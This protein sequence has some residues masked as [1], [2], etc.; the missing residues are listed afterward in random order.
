MESK[1]SF[2]KEYGSYKLGTF[3]CWFGGTD[4]EKPRPSYFVENVLFLNDSSSFYI[5]NIKK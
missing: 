4:K 3:Q 2:P 5:S 1:N